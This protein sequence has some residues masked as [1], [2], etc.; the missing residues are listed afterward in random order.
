MSMIPLVLHSAHF[1]AKVWWTLNCDTSH[2]YHKIL[3]PSIHGRF[4]IE[5]WGRKSSQ[6][7]FEIM[8]A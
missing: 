8:I 7:L 4:V 5:R 1:A 2:A 3:K 6:E